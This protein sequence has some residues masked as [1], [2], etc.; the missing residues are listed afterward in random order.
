MSSTTTNLTN[1]NFMSESKYDSL[2]EIHDDELYAVKIDG[3][4]GEQLINQN[5]NEDPVKVWTGTRAEYNSIETKNNDTIYNVTD[6]GNV[7]QSLL[8]MIYPVGSIYIGTMNICPLSALFGT[9]E[10]VSS[11]RVLQGAD[12]SHAAGTTIEAGLPNITGQ[13]ALQWNGEYT[14]QVCNGSNR[15][16]ALAATRI[17]L[18]AGTESANSSHGAIGVATQYGIAMDASLSSPI[19][20]NSSTVQP[21][22]FVVNIWRRVG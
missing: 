21:P 1:I 4:D 7:T 6:D 20:G 17:S 14:G 3:L 18:G 15:N 10:K 19:Y 11:G 13:D 8:E 12:D 22:A 5:P 16:G 9:W 2:T